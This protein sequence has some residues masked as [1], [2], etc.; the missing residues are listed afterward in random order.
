VGVGRLRIGVT[1][2]G[3]GGLEQSWR[4]AVAWGRVDGVVV[5]TKAPHLLLAESLPRAVVVHCT[6]TGLAPDWEP[7]VLP[8]VDAIRAYHALVGQY[9]GERVVL[10]VDPI[11]PE[12]P[13]LARATAVLAQAAGRVRI[14]FLDLYPHVRAR[15]AAAGLVLAQADF[16]APLVLRR[17]LWEHWGRPEVCGEPGLPCTGCVSMRDVQAMGLDAGQLS[18]QRRGQRGTCACV[19]EK[20]ELLPARQP[21]AHGCTYCY[22]RGGSG[23]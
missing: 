12:P 5:I 15:M 2:R 22:W 9:G 1:E 13:W 7:H 18:G 16:H 10:R 21:C 6:I 20:V 19:A 14:S 23:E 4:G 3:D 17:E 8:V 11:I